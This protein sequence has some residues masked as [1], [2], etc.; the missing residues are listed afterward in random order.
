MALHRDTSLFQR[1]KV[2]RG[3]HGP[4]VA[5]RDARRR[6]GPR[7]HVVHLALLL[8][9]DPAAQV[10]RTAQQGGDLREDRRSFGAGSQ[11]ASQPDVLP[12]G[13]IRF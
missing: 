4:L 6:P 13:L 9:G 10:Q 12:G 1:R 8:E 11:Q 7:G 3:S 2:H 5:E